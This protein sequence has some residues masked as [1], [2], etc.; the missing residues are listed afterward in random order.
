VTLALICELGFS[1]LAAAQFETR[2]T[3]LLGSSPFSVAVGDFNHDGKLDVAVAASQIQIFLGNGD[4][5]FQA[6]VTYSDPIGPLSVATA[7]LN[8]DGNL[9]LVVATG[10]V[11][12]VSVLRGNGDG[13]FQPAMNFNTIAGPTFVGVGDFNGDHKPDLIVVDSP[14]VS[15]L[16]GNG[17]GT[18]GSSIDTKTAFPPRAVGWGDFDHS[19]TLDLA[20]AESFF[21]TD[22]V[23]I[24]LGNGDGSFHEAAT[25]ATQAGPQTVAVGDFRGN[26]NLDL[27]VGLQF[28]KISVFLG[29]GDGTFQPA[30]SYPADDPVWIAVADFNGDGKLDL[31]AADLSFNG[32]TIA[33]GVSVFLGN[34]DGTFQS[35]TNYPTGID[36]PFVAVGDF[37]NDHQPDLAALDSSLGE[38]TVLLNTGVVSFSPTTP[39]TFPP[40]F[41]GKIGAP[42]TATLTNTGTTD[43]SISSIFVA[44]PFRLSKLTTCGA[45][46]APGAS[47]A[48][49]A[50]FKPLTT[51][52]F[53]GAVTIVDS[54]S[55]KPQVIELIGSGTVITV[56]PGQLNFPPQRV[57]T[58]SPPQLVT[59]TNRSSAA[60]SVDY[61]LQRGL[62][63]FDFFVS[64][65][66]GSQIGSGASC[67][68]AVSFAPV[69]T[70][71]QGGMLDVSIA[72]MGNPA[73]VYLRGTGN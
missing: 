60:V 8:H 27:A 47:C 33:S 67:T 6:P 62:D 18:F 23:A 65:N 36:T 11:A 9:D 72:G 2:S 21:T 39:L 7:D 50:T 58:K 64:N 14:Y 19:G 38:L 40:Q 46:V 12:N 42:L 53:T 59:I 52:L 44:S 56:S 61:I 10:L 45:S 34:G 43:L 55:S 63:S 54:A 32:K 5:T 49:T 41:L 25:Y 29:N 1:D 28:N 3:T 31:V 66:C 57:G 68:A 26:G 22:Q 35:P 13:T 48:I 71:K 17:D 15:V 16:L 20:V 51:G 73:V 24:L 37:N 70:G 30:M 69:M 4:G